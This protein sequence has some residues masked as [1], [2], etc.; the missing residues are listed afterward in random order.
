M[1]LTRE[2]ERMYSGEMGDVLQKAIQVL[3]K[4]GEA[5]GADRLIE[6]K[7]AHVSGVSYMNIGEAG[8][9]FVEDLRAR[10]ARVRVYS[11]LNPVGMDL[12]RWRDMGV[13]A[14]FAEKQKRL[15]VTLL[16][17]GFQPSFTCTPYYLRP[18]RM[19]EHLS[20]AESSAAAMANTYYGAYTNR[21]A[22]PL[23]LFSAI[24]GKTYNAGLHLEENRVPTVKVVLG[25]LETL[26]ASDEGVASAVG[27]LVGERLSNEI[28]LIPLSVTPSFDSV[29]AYTASAGASG[30]LALSYIRG[31]TPGYEK[32][33]K[34]QLERVEIT[35]SEVKEF[36]KEE[37]AALSESEVIFV[38]CPH[39]SLSELQ[40]LYEALRGCKSL[41]REIVVS[42][43]RHVLAQ[44]TEIGLAQNLESLGVR[45][46]ADT[47]PIVS[48]AFRSKYPLL[49][50]YSGKASFYLPRQQSQPVILTSF[51]R[52]ASVAC[53]E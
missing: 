30:N 4:V 3:V 7:H 35:R 51:K 6:V 42:T 32:F 21:E 20:W 43:S 14:E 23:A 50:T 11:T 46:Y 27:Y 33:E 36:L 10:R 2:E 12:E 5:L 37:D 41:K 52:L 40:K 45:I 16:E 13:P 25:D 39:A 47:C 1:Y 48:P 28:P 26:F 9:R 19:G 53:G 8:L 22:G 44:A 24:V 34:A 38:G 29:K 49:V 18:P 17:M 31:V 15:V